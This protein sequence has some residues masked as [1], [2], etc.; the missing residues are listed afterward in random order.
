MEEWRDIPGYEKYYQVSNKG[1]V[2]GLDR[3][4]DSWKGQKIKGKTLAIHK[5]HKGYVK[6]YL[7][8][9]GQAKGKFIHILVAMSF[10][11]PIPK[12][13]QVNHINGKKSDNRPENLEYCTASY[14]MLHSHRILKKT[15]NLQGEKH[16][17]AK[18]TKKDVLDIR[19]LYDTGRFTQ[20]ELASLFSVKCPA[21][22]K[23]VLRQKWTH[24]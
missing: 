11:G 13:K 1:R 7:T 3:Y 14:N 19:R 6:A 16:W 8:K 18:L 21:I 2:R 12:N 5:H 24:I 22:T 20:R 4:S 9:N 23:I 15:S 17:N 10:I